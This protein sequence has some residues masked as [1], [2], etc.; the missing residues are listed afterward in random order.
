[1]HQFTISQQSIY[2]Y[3]APLTNIFTITNHYHPFLT[4]LYQQDP[5]LAAN[6]PS[7]LG[8]PNQL[9]GCHGEP[10]GKATGLSSTKM[11]FCD[12]GTKRKADLSRSYCHDPIDPVAGHPAPQPWVWGV[13][14][15]RTDHNSTWDLETTAKKERNN[16]LLRCDI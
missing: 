1:M 10:C 14:P 13:V 2:H 4:I 15:R 3:W 8:K 16:N 9:L 11:G 7:S 6:L 5:P 12:S